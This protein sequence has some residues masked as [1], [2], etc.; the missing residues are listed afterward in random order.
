MSL[1]LAALAFGVLIAFHEAGHMWVARKVGMRVDRFSVGFGPVLLSKTVGGTEYVLCA[2][3]LGGY[4][5]IAGM[6]PEDEV[7]ADD[8][9][10]YPNRPAWA[11]MLAIAAGP[12]ANYLL[13]FLIGI[14]LLLVPGKVQ[15]VGS[16]RLGDLLP[17]GPAASAGLQ[18]GDEVQRVGGRAVHDFF[19]IKKAVNDAAKST[20]GQ[21]IPIVVS[22]DG[23]PAEVAVVPQET[24]GDFRIGVAPW[25]RPEPGLP[26]A[27]AIPAA[28]VRL[29]T[30]TA[31]SWE[32]LTRLFSGA[33]RVTD[34]S[35]PIGMI[36]MTAAQAKKGFID[37]VQTV[38]GLSVA[39]G[40]FN[41]LPIP[42]LDGGRLIFL[43]W[44]AISRRRVSA[45]VENAAH[46]VGLFLLLGLIAFISYGDVV[47]RLRGG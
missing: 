29:W 21:A 10:S 40:F 22:R 23:R 6:S 14:P 12:A 1:L 28:G 43:A 16:T 17:G 36:S 32:H 5:K 20:P 35:G 24:G 38:W 26:L 39:I 18:A 44:E 27:Q 8:P 37:Y 2:I 46:T 7:A 45:R 25:M 41:L 47:R 13:A 33:A 9:A 3:P 19:E 31:T 34:L 15:D 11:R 42:A 4:V 30:A